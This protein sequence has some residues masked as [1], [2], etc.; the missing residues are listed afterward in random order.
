MPKAS[1]VTAPKAEHDQTKTLT[2]HHQPVQSPANAFI[3]LTQQRSTG[4]SAGGNPLE[5]WILPVIRIVDSCNSRILLVSNASSSLLSW[6]RLLR[7]LVA[8]DAPHPGWG[9]LEPARCSCPGAATGQRFMPD[10]WVRRR[11]SRSLTGVR[12]DDELRGQRGNPAPG[13][14]TRKD[15]VSTSLSC[16]LK[17]ARATARCCKRAITPVPDP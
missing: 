3:R 15:A 14:D 6:R 9:S 2:P 17:P 12:H 13:W 1:M 16:L 7:L 8:S 5:A 4:G 11:Y 10:R